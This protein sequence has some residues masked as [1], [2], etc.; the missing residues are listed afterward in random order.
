MKFIHRF[1]VII[2][3]AFIVSCSIST[4]TETEQEVVFSD[5][6]FQKTADGEI[7]I[8]DI[9]F[10]Q[11]EKTGL[12]KSIG[13]SQAIT[14]KAADGSTFTEMMDSA[15]NKSGNRCFNNH[16]LVGCIVLKTN[17]KGEKEILVYAQNGEVK[18]L[19]ADKFE[20]ILTVSANDAAAAA[21][22]YEG[23]RNNP[24]PAM[25][26]QKT[27]NSQPP[28]PLPSYKFPVQSS[29]PAPVET[30]EETGQSAEKPTE[31]TPEVKDGKA[32]QQGETDMKDRQS[33]KRNEN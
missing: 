5:D 29:T 12:D 30:T 10:S 27:Q 21:E 16:P 18:I 32:Q 15:G 33:D 14:T 20:N 1:A 11:S 22:I 13:N 6:G 28:Q 9:S 23:R 4:T 17:V 19:T 7:I 31:N 2:L 3:S 25:F 24:S 26:T 8:D